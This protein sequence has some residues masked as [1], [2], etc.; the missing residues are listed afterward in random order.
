M[1]TKTFLLF[2]LI[3]TVKIFAQTPIQTIKGLVLDASSNKPIKNAKFSKPKV[4]KEM[5]FSRI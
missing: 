5:K 4:G 1:K 2:L 3:I